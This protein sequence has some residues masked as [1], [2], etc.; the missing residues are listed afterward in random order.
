MH[1]DDVKKYQAEKDQL[2]RTEGKHPGQH[3][4][5]ATEGMT[6]EEE[7]NYYDESI[8]KHPADQDSYGEAVHRQVLKELKGK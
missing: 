7:Y 2:M 4:R 8:K 5:Y 3:K 6:A 1:I